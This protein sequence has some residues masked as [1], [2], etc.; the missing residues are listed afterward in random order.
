MATI[1]P[2]AA[3][4]RQPADRGRF[5]LSYI[6]D[7][8][9]LPTRVQMT[10]RQMPQGAPDMLTAAGILHDLTSVI[11]TFG[12][13]GVFAAIWAAQSARRVGRP[14]AVVRR[15]RQDRRS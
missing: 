6:R 15:P 1:M 7:I 14:A 13:F 11:G 9:A 5:T 10:L 4:R 3:R 12:A 8:A 2:M